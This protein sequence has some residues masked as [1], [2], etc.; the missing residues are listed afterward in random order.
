M[1]V[2]V[3]QLSNACKLIILPSDSLYE[4]LLSLLLD[5]YKWIFGVLMEID[6]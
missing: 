6:Y 4:L 1:S 2:I 5:Y 3:Q